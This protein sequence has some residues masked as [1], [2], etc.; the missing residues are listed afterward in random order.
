MNNISKNS[1]VARIPTALNTDFFI[2]W[3][4]FLKPLH[5]LTNKEMSL[6]GTF[7]KKRHELS[8][9]ISDERILDSYLMSEDIRREV[10]EECDLTA[11]HMQCLL[12]KFHKSGILKGDSINKKF[13]PN[14]E[15][16]STS[17]K[18]IINFELDDRTEIK[19]STEGSSDSE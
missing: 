13:I 16:G 12:S 2:I 5:K 18:L 10:R 15:I 1:N 6:L 3:L 17:Y 8:Y 7:L 14:V 9:S 4:S 19:A 11:N